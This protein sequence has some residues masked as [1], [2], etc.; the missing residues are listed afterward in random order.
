M[1]AGWRGHCCQETRP[2]CRLRPSSPL[3][4]ALS[5]EPRDRP[6]VV[7]MVRSLP[8]IRKRTLL[9]TRTRYLGIAENAGAWQ[10]EAQTRATNVPHPASAPRHSGGSTCTA[11][12]ASS[13]RSCRL[14]V[15]PHHPP[16][17]LIPLPLVTPPGP[18]Q[19]PDRGAGT[20]SSIDYPPLVPRW[21]LRCPRPASPSLA[22][23]MTR[24]PR[25]CP[26]ETSAL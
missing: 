1:K 18:R 3:Q 16:S 15:L 9:S 23:T 13:R 24:E 19:A 2:L 17:S 7:L 8:G 26:S 4:D 11:P 21:L 20:I 12:E 22:S 10:N 5:A 25:R 6:L 14:S